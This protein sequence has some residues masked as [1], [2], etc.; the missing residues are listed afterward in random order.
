M[1]MCMRACVSV[2]VCVLGDEQPSSEAQAR[3]A[4]KEILPKAGRTPARGDT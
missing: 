1:R 4:T 3:P 2:C